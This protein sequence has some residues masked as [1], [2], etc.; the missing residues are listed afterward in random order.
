MFLT[1]TRNKRQLSPK[2]ETTVGIIRKM[3]TEVLRMRFEYWKNDEEI[4]GAVPLGEY[5]H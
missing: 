1:I 5:S 3:S 4:G 2:A